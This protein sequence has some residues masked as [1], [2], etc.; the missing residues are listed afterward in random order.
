[1]PS[2]KT[3]FP[4]KYIKADDLGATRPIGTIAQVTFEDVG[5]GA[6]QERKLVVSFKEDTLK[7][8]VLNLINSDTISEITG[9]EDYERWPEHRV[10]L[11]A[12]RTE[13]QGKRV[14]CI[15]LAPPP[16]DSRGSKAVSKAAPAPRA[17]DPDD[18]LPGVDDL[19]GVL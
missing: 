2:Y 5:T 15:R 12:S 8:L 13:F 19:A 18:P 9:T 6:K 17:D 1:M 11:F 10:Q 16:P 4:S 14:P 3:A 7:S